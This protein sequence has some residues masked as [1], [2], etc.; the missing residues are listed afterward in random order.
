LTGTFGVCSTFSTAGRFGRIGVGVF[1][2]DGEG[3]Y[4]GFLG[5]PGTEF[6]IKFTE[7]DVDA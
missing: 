7:E 3:S 1:T 6:R 2:E 4:E 5:V